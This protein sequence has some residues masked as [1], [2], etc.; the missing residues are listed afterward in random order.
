MAHLEMMNIVYDSIKPTT[1]QHK[2]G[3][4]MR[5]DKVE[6]YRANHPLG[7][8]HKTGDDFGWF[9]IPSEYDNKKLRVM[10]APSDS[11]WQHISVSK[12]EGRTPL[13][14]EMCQIKD[15]FWDEEE[16]VVQFHPRKSEYVNNAKN[17]L[18]LWARRDGFPTPDSLL[19]G[20]K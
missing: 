10:A 12:D 14:R 7:F 1:P 5:F 4:G 13:W 15:L 6:K 19:V 18:H 11:E 9:E 2:G 16:V 17:C 20:I 8:K 3:E